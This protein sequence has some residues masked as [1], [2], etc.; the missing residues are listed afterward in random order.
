MLTL[1]GVDGSQGGAVSISTNPAD[2]VFN[3]RLSN[4]KF[5]GNTGLN[6]IFLCD[7]NIALFTSYRWSRIYFWRDISHLLRLSV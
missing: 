1:V 5:T 2:I 3:T 4:C 7:I 6:G